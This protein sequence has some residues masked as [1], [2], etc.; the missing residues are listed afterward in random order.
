MRLVNQSE[1]SECGLACLATAASAFGLHIDLS[2]LRR[3]F[4]AASRGTTLA[5]LIQYGQRLNFACR[6]LRLELDDIGKLR[7]PAILHWDLNHFVVLSRVKASKVTVL[8]P[9]VGERVLSLAEVSKHFTG[10]A[11]ELTPT[12]DF[13]PADTR[14]RIGLTQLLGKVAGLRRSMVQFLLIAL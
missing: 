2:E 1:A 3:R 6:A 10:V 13:L 14:R 11:L 4:G 12:V 9:A 8:D 7:I 5:Q